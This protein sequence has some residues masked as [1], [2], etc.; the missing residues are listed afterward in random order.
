MTEQYFSTKY[1]LIILGVRY[2]PSVCYKLDETIEPTIRELAE[3]GEVRLY[4]EKV[5]FVNGVPIPIKRD[6]EVIGSNAGKESL[7]SMNA[8]TEEITEPA[9]RKGKS[10]RAGKRSFE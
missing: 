4:A 1:V 7:P 6:A 5:R 9:L 10:S 8:Q 3:K 2:I